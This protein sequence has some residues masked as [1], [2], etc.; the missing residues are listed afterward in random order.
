MRTLFLIALCLIG[1]AVIADAGS[2]DPLAGR[3]ICIDP[4]HGGTADTDSTG[5]VRPAS[6]RSGST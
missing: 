1:A 3:T 6:G 5:S 4:G 2:D